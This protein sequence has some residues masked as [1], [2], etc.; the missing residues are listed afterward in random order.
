MFRKCTNNPDRF[1]YIC[2]KLTLAHRKLPINQFVKLAYH[3]Y[4]GVKLG[5]QEKPF[6][7]HI[8]CKTCVESLRSWSNNKSS[9]LPFGIPM[10]WRE[11]KD[12]ITDC[13]FCMTDLRG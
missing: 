2:G 7:P 9:H 5:D 3:Q 13:Y 11:G 4:F 1:C 10:V 12:H 8:C 6:A